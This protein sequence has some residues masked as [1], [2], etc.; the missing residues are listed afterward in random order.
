[1]L[2]KGS[3]RISG[4]KMF[5][6]EQSFELRSRLIR[7]GDIA[8]VHQ[9]LFTINLNNLYLALFIVGYY[10]SQKVSDTVFAS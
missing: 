2:L 7:D 5:C 4:V 10:F 8:H 3:E 6:K 1:M 9:R